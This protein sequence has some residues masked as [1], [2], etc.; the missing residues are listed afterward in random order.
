MKYDR[1]DK[2]QP[3]RRGTWF[4][5]DKLAKRRHVG[6]VSVA[7]PNI[8]RLGA[9]IGQTSWW[10][11]LVLVS[12]IWKALRFCRRLAAK[13]AKEGFCFAA[14]TLIHTKEGLKPIEDIKVGD[15]VLS[16]PEDNKGEN[17][18]K[19]VTRTMQFDDK[20]VWRVAVGSE[21]THIEQAVIVTGNHPFY[22]VDNNVR[23]SRKGWDRAD[24]LEDF[25]DYALLKDEEHCIVTKVD[26][27]LKTKREGIAWVAS[28]R[29][30][31]WGEY[32]GDHCHGCEIDLRGGRIQ[33]Q[34]ELKLSEFCMEGDTEDIEGTFGNHSASGYVAPWAY[35]CTVYNFEVEDF[36]T[37]FV[38]ELGI[39]VHDTQ[40][41]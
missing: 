21:R 30:V 14:G 1:Y 37:Y 25:M 33:E 35:Q 27:L 17:A 20:P 24:S 40:Q 4:L 7:Q 36:H 9:N 28:G 18:Y 3:M 23:S 34:T 41:A 11:L 29:D 32:W 15:W 5:P 12:P 26:P 13:P 6:W 2:Q 19:R 22:I 31:S 38:G 16:R 8:G 39:W 10:L